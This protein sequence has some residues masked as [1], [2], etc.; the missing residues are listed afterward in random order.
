M[1]KMFVIIGDG[2]NM[3]MGIPVTMDANL[4]LRI[5]KNQ[6]KVATA[7]TVT[8]KVYK[9]YSIYISF[10]CSS[11]V[12]HHTTPAIN[13]HGLGNSTAV[14]PLVDSA[15]WKVWKSQLHVPDAEQWNYELATYMYCKLKI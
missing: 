3:N 10:Q 13:H 5:L 9:Y 4:A 7:K 6:K 15:T 2:A 12:K 11:L 8:G 1:T 14:P